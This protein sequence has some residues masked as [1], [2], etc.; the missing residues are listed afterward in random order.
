[1]K[2]RIVL[3]LA[4]ILVMASSASVAAG[5]ATVPFRAAL[6]T[7]CVEDWDLDTLIVTIDCSG[8]GQATH[9]GSSTL[10]STTYVDLVSPTTPPPWVQLG[11]VTLIAANG[12]RLNLYIEGT[13]APGGP[14][15]GSWEVVD[16][17]TG[18]FAGMM[19][20]GVYLY[21]LGGDAWHLNLEGTLTK[22][23]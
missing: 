4:L 1:M 11:G 10:E 22:P 12:D 18:R 17:G 7:S 14:G 3:A 2:A 23:E 20:S 19:G 15:E 13:I 16:G 5:G 8:E 21:S 6:Q 9:L